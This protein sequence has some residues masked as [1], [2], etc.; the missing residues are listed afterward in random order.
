MMVVVVVWLSMM[1]LVAAE[2]RWL[3]LCGSAARHGNDERCSY[4]RIVQ[5][6]S[7]IISKD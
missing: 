7:L 1:P 2:A 4:D 3:H 6:A 5:R